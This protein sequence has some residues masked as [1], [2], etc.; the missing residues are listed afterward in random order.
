MNRYPR[1]LSGTALALA[2]ALAGAEDR[3]TV[4]RPAAP[5]ASPRASAAAAA[6]IPPEK[7]FLDFKTGQ[8]REATAEDLAHLARMRAEETEVVASGIS[9]IVEHG[10]GM[11]SAN[12]PESYHLALAV[13][14]RADGTLEIICAPNRSIGRRLASPLRPRAEER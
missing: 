7:A 3:A 1:L 12:L 10:H 9:P 14:E 11:R 8:F 5:A 6:A 13:R 4:S 2:A